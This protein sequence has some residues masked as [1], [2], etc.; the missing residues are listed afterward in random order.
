M[1]SIPEEIPVIKNFNVSFKPNSLN[2][3]IG[4]VGHGKTSVLLAILGE[5][6]KVSGKLS[7]SGR[8][9]YVEQEPMIFSGTIRSNILFGLKY[10]KERYR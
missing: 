6:P 9:A 7:V 3:I 8:L 2:V 5:L 4:S 10:E 1:A